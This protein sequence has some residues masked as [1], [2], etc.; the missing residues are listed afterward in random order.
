VAVTCFIDCHKFNKNDQYFLIFFETLINDEY[1]NL[2]K[3]DIVGYGFIEERELD[4]RINKLASA[5]QY[6]DLTK[7]MIT[8]YEY[9]HFYNTINIRNGE[10]LF[11][12]GRLND[13]GLNGLYSKDYLNSLKMI[14]WYTKDRK[15]RVFITSKA[16][17]DNKVYCFYILLDGRNVN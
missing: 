9:D 8:K 11:R 14:G 2:N 16:T 17:I 13:I 10:H 3:A 12:N 1:P 6:D 15:N 7:N 5:Y 4:D